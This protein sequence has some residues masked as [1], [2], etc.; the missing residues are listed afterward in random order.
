[1]QYKELTS[2]PGKQMQ[3]MVVLLQ[4]EIAWR[5]QKLLRRKLKGRV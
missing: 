3:V 2:S 1:M 5:T 4:V